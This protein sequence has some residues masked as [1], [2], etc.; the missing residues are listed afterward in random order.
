MCASDRRNEG[1]RLRHTAAIQL[2][3]LMSHSANNHIGIFEASW[4]TQRERERERFG[5]WCRMDKN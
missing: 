5:A 3:G 4:K 2:H 1:Q